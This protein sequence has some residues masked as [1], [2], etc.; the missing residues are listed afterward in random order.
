MVES[1]VVEGW[2]VQEQTRAAL[3]WLKTRTASVINNG[4]SA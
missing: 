3:A 4:E 2:E 1:G